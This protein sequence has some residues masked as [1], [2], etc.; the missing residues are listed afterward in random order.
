MKTL[1]LSILMLAAAAVDD[2]RNITIIG[3]NLN[4]GMAEYIRNH[5]QTELNKLESDFGL[6][7]N[8]HLDIIIAGTHKEFK[9]SAPHGADIPV[10]AAGVAYPK[11]NLIIINKERINDNRELER[12]LRHEIAHVALGSIFIKKRPPLWLNEGLTMHLADDWGISRQ[13]AIVR[14]MASGRLI[15]LERLTA[16]FPENSLDAET[17][18]AQSYYFLAFLRDRFGGKVV[19]KLIK[20]LADGISPNTAFFHVTGMDIEDL[21]E[22]F[23]K[24][25]SSR[26]SIYWIITGPYGFWVL[27]AALLAAAVIIKKRAAAKKLAEWEAES[28]ESEGDSFGA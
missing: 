26:F 13:I 23:N 2:G 10:W 14:A 27:A 15:P 19:G 9:R 18:Y 16:G 25:L 20:H 11:L 24:W 1:I 28:D 5:T 3:Q 8:G 22:D 4:R 6:L 21:E 7:V 12:V 17:A